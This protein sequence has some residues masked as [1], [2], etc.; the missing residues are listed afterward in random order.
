MHTGLIAGVVFL[1]VMMG[2]IFGVVQ[3]SSLINASVEQ[4]LE[5]IQDVQ[6]AIVDFGWTTPVELVKAG[7]TYFSSLFTVVWQVFNTPFETGYWALIPYVMLSPYI[8]PIVLM[9]IMLVIGIL[10]SQRSA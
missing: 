5:A 3:G 7:V 8:I 6:L 9:L 2:L 1:V 10:Q 4:N